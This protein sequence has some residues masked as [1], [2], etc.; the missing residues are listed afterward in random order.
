MKYT[1]DTEFLDDGKSIEMIS[2][3]LVAEDGREFYRV[4]LDAD[5]DR[6]LSH[7]YARDGWMLANVLDKLP[8]TGDGHEVDWEIDGN[9]E[10]VVPRKQIAAELL[11]FVSVGLTPDGV[12]ETW[13]WYS[14]SDHVVLYQLFGPMVD[15]PRAIPRRTNCLK[16]EQI[17]RGRRGEYV[18]I[19]KQEPAEM[20]HHALYDA[21]HDMVIARLLGVI[22]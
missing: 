12:A 9:H 7:D 21:K 19:P 10:D 4:A 16:Q 8:H 17:M 14:A 15:S 20:E 1:L 6:I 18:V 5:Y 2:I 13:A 22:S 3:G 11:E